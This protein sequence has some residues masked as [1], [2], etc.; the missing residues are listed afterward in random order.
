MEWITVIAFL[1]VGIGLIVVE[2]IFVPGTTIVGI[3]GFGL[4]LVG[5]ILSFNLFGRST[6]WI[7]FGISG[8]VATALVYW[9]LRSKAWTRF[10]LKD[11][12][13]SRVNE[14]AYQHLQLGEEGITVST[15]RP[16]G[17]ADFN[18]K[19]HEVATTGNYIESGKK[20]R[21]IKISSNQILVEPVN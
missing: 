16:M 21:I 8:A 18:G 5:I 6:G 10:S 15:L 17:K 19:M 13:N 20:I 12:I 7:T 11:T 2:I 9:S 14:G 1:V 4:A 3:L